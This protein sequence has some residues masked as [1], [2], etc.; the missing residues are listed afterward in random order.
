MI[1]DNAVKL[2]LTYITDNSRP[3]TVR[4]FSYTL[5]KFKNKFSGLDI[6][7]VKESAI[8]EFILE[9]TSGCSMTT[10]HHRVGVIRALFNF[11]IEVT[12]APFTNPCIRPMIKKLFKGTKFSS[13]KLLEK[14]VI[15][16]IIFRTTDDRDRLILELMGRAGMRIGEVLN[17]RMQDINFDN[18]TIVV[19]EPKSGRP[20]EKVYI[21][22]KLCSKL[23]SYVNKYA[24]KSENKV[25]D[26]SYSTTYR[27][28]KDAGKMVHASL[29]PHDLRRHTATQA[30]RSGIPLEIVSKVILR[31]ANI[32]TTQRYLGAIDPSEAHRWIEQ[33]NG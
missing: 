15:D 3:N 9:I 21:T 28:V 4:A 17:M 26:V 24:V 33:L 5:M 14:D 11:V 12:E 29:R 18:F 1:V 22:K 8:I 16:E 32:S 7:T 23:Q 2:Y 19:T 6:E 27:M 13:P 25:F 31:H 20:G 30:S 10:K